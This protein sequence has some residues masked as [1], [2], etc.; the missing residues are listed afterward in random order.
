MVT[1]PKGRSTNDYLRLGLIIS[2][3][4]GKPYSG[5]SRYMPGIDCSLFTQEV[6]REFA[7]VTLGRTVEDQLREG[8]EVLRNRLLPG[9]LVFFTTER[10]R[11][12]HVGI[13]VGFNEFAHASS[14]EGV[15][16]TNMSDS[17]WAKR[18]ETARR[19]VEPEKGD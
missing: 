17:Y 14:S 8:R 11:I 3:R 12:S 10:D 4:L 15:V 7:K 1:A 5:S 19:A 16:I 6:Y 2:S 18:Y 13:Y 9:D